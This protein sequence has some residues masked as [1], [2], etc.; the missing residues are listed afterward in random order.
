MGQMGEKGLPFVPFC[1]KIKE[2]Y[3]TQERKE[4]STMVLN[5]DQIRS[6][7]RGVDRVEERED[8]FYFF[9]FTKAQEQA[10]LDGGNEGFCKKI[11][12]TAG[13]RLAFRTD[14]SAFSFDYDFSIGSSRRYAWF[15]VYVNGQMTE[16]FGSSGSSVLGGRARITLPEGKKTV[17]LYFPWTYRTVLSNVELKDATLLEGIS[18][19]HTMLTFGDSITQ[20]YDAVYPSLS[21]A[22]LL[23][24]LMDADAINKGIGG[25]IFFPAL[26]EE[27]D[28]LDPDFVTVAYGSN[29]WSHKTYE[30]TKARCRAF[31]T[32]LS[33]LYPNARIFAITPIWRADGMRT[34]T[35]F[36]AP[37]TE[38]DALI[39]EACA[40]LPNITV[41]NG[42]TFVPGRSEFYADLR[43][44]PNDLG[45]G[46]YA[47]NLYA[48]IVKML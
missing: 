30:D 40:D 5:L 9:R 44:H 34:T 8:G 33:E 12:A 2:L 10:Y 47:Q 11:T 21:Y 48:E 24:R 41:I 36:G 14:A 35:Q 43:L 18:R 13:V 42:W 38:V 29:D 23:A 15:D 28:A 4:L 17:E 27:P 39:R 6:I 25:E 1:D 19:K 22:S 37:A 3:R 32:R 45:F 20:G 26:L 7:V 46:L 31:Y 16:H